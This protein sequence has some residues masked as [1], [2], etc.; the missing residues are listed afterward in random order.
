MNDSILLDP[1]AEQAP[2]QRSRLARPASLEGKVV[3]LLDISKPR[4]NVCL[5]RIEEQ[6]A[7]MGI[8]VKRY[9]KPTFTRVA[10][11]ELKQQMAA[12]VDLLVEGLA[13]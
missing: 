5:D 7:A 10:P 3:G 9:N 6:L 1:T 4:G 12:E 13:D 11:T 8:E 2:A